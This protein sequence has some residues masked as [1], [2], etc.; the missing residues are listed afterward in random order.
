MLN[1]TDKGY[2]NPNITSKKIHE[3][4]VTAKPDP[5]SEQDR[6]DCLHALNILDSSSGKSF[7]RIT[8]L[9]Q[10]V[11]NAPVAAITL[12][13]RDRQ[14]IKSIIGSEL[15]QTSRDEAICSHTILSD[16]VLVIPDASEDDR[17]ANSPLVCKAPHIRFYAGAPIIC[18]RNQRIGALCVLSNESRTNFGASD[19]ATLQNMAQLVGDMLLL[20]KHIANGKQSKREA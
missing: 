2:S 8:A 4:W 11:F 1:Y 15:K 20:R 12:I 3:G 7:D 19:Q 17:F 6:I 14:W 5:F 10:Q 13:D 16:D 9:T 18:G